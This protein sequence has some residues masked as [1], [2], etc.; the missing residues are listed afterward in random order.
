[1]GVSENDLNEHGAVSNVVAKQMAEGARKKSNVDIAISTTGIAGPT[2]GTEEKPVGTVFI[3]F[4]SKKETVVKR[5]Q[6]DGSRLEIKE[7]FCNAA[8]EMILSNIR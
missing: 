7:K 1:M 2:G 8:L 6:F 4:S 5:F 3:G